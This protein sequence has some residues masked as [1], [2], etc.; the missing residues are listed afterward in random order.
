VQEKA[1]T[2]VEKLQPGSSKAPLTSKT[3]APSYLAKIPIC[4]DDGGSVMTGF[5]QREEANEAALDGRSSATTQRE[6]DPKAPR[7]RQPPRIFT[8]EGVASYSVGP[9]TK[10]WH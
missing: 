3:E 2:Y 5:T 7:R 8:D 1:Q 10:P 9:L 6:I 4:A